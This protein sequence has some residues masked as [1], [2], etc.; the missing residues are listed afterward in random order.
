MMYLLAAP[1]MFLNKLPEDLASCDVATQGPLPGEQVMQLKC[2]PV[3]IFVNIVQ[4]T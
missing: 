3:R 1:G 2:A 4:I